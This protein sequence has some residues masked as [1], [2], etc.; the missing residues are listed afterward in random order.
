MQFSYRITKGEIFFYFQLV[1]ALLLAGKF[2]F[3][4]LNLK[5]LHLPRLC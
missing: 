2:Q 3:S 5:P 1:S 4:G